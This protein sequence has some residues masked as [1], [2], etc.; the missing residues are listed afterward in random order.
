VLKNGN[1]FVTNWVGASGGP[2]VHAFE[3]TRDKRVVYRFDDHTIVK[4]AT[5]VLV[6]DE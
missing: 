4:S 5:T 3:V 6:L 1:L 2:G